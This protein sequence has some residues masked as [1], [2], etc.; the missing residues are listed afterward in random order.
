MALLHELL[1]VE[2][3]LEGTASKIQEE[4]EKTF[5][6]RTHH[7]LGFVKNFRPDDDEDQMNELPSEHQEIVTTVSDK[8]DYVEGHMVRYWDALLQ[9]EIANQNAKA[10][11]I[12][13][14][15][16][17]A[18]DVPVGFLLGMESRLKRYRNVL[19]VIP[20]LDPGIAWDKDLTKDASG[21]TYVTRNPEE[22]TRTIQRPG[23][24]V[25]YEAT[26][27]HPAQIEK[28]MEKVRVGI[29]KKITWSG[30]VSPA[31]KS[32]LLGRLDKLIREVKKARMRAN[33]VKVESVKI[34]DVF[35]DFI[36]N[37]KVTG[38]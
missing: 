21:N 10:D 8:L 31:E 25:M 18:K 28:F 20:T 19:S 11:I 27:E 32:Q 30:M 3:E 7:F 17:L 29:F 4:A 6:D 34:S 22:T 26:H 33:T 1:A 9:K 15:K 12:I 13:D 5:K 14:G 23:F 35:I 38:G 24:R 2:S 37:N 36:R 16:T